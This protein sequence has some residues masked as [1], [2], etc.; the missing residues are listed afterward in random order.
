VRKS[1]T[2]PMA[3]LERERH[4]ADSDLGDLVRQS[5]AWRE[6][7]DLLQSAPTQRRDPGVLSALGGGREA[8]ETGAG[9]VPAETAHHPQHH[10]PHGDAVVGRLWGTQT[11]EC[12][13]SK[14]V[15]HRASPGGR[16]PP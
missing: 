11:R 8:Q 5:P 7:D 13:T 4:L 3:Y 16:S 9:R 10:G 6:R 15:A 12:S 1:L 2:A 14:T